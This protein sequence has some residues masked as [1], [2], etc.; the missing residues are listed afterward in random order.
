MQVTYS[1]NILGRIFNGVG[2]P[3]D[4]GSSLQPDPKVAI[5]SASVNPMKRVLASKMIR[6]NVPMIDL[7][8]TLVEKSKNS[9]LFSF[10]RTL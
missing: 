2:E 5:E 3:L 1:N 6:T 9:H 8:N 4:G 7:F 10:R